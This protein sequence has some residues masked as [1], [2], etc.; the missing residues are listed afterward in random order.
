[1]AA[2]LI[3]LGLALVPIISA[4]ISRHLSPKVG[5]ATGWVFGA[6]VGCTCGW[7][8]FLLALAGP[9]AAIILGSVGGLISGA[10]VGP[11]TAHWAISKQGGWKNLSPR[12][13]LVG[14]ILLPV[15]L[16]SGVLAVICIVTRSE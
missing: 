1:M 15:M 7:I 10:I 6:L 13:R 2:L 14:Y 3:P 8:V 16:T 11:I 5:V 4:I 9:G 12:D